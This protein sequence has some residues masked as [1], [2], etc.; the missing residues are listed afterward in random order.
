MTSACISG[1]FH[2][3]LGSNQICPNQCIRAWSEQPSGAT[4]EVSPQLWL[5]TSE[6][7][8]ADVETLPMLKLVLPE[9]LSALGWLGT[10]L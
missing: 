8:W 1:S 7:D 5:E 3:L 4:V 6:L 2:A 10:V 9:V